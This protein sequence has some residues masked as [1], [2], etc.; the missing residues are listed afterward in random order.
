GTG[1]WWKSACAHSPVTPDRG[2][3]GSDM[4]PDVYTQDNGPIAIETPLGKDKLLLESISGY[5]AVSEPFYFRLEMLAPADPPV[6]FDKLLNQKVAVSMWLTAE[7]S[8]DDAADKKRYFH[9]IITR[10]SQGKPVRGVDGKYGLV[11]Y[12]A[13]L[14]P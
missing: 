11:R 7:A 4:P 1:E 13:E 8:A 6:A 14:R 5:E 12:T 10:L 2:R 3:T 9:G